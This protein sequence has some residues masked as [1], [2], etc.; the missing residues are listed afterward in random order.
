MHNRA[1]TAGATASEATGRPSSC[2]PALQTGATMTVEQ[3]I[4]VG[5]NGYAVALD[6]DTGRIVW[7]QWPNAWRLRDDAVG[8]RPL[9]CFY[10]RLPVLPRPADRQDP[11][12]QSHEGLRSRHPPRRCCPCA[13]PAAKWWC[14]KPQKRHATA[15]R[16]TI[17][18]SSPSP[19]APAST[20]VRTALDLLMPERC[21]AQPPPTSSG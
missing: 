14:S 15:R 12:A 13:G 21:P 16:N 4:F 9:D 6:R 19:A 1:G 5:L 7:S 3:L 17:Q 18:L 20:A 10:E 2:R 11:V 8:R